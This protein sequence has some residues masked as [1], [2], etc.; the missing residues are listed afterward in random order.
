MTLRTIIKMG[1]PRLLR[2]AQPVTEFDT[3]D[4]HL[5]VADMWQTMDA[6]GGVGLAAPQIAVDLQEM[7]FGT[8]EPLARDPDAPVIARTALV[9]PV[10]EPLD[11]EQEEGWE[12]CLSIPGLRAMVPRWKRIRYSGFDV[13]GD[14]VEQVAEG[15]HARVVQHEYDHLKGVLYTMRIRDF[16]RFGYTDVLF[17]PQD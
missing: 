3:D 6:E 14:P 9:N 12:G 1:D 7:V 13:Y 15:F 2:V 11:D 16:G 5:L 10:I 4:L 8:G 17:P